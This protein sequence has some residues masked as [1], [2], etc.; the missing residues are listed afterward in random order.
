MDSCLT[1]LLWLLVGC[2]NVNAGWWLTIPSAP[3]ANGG[4]GSLTS[5]S[6]YWDTQ[7]SFQFFH[8]NNQ[9]SGTIPKGTYGE[10]IE[11]YFCTTNVDSMPLGSYCF[12]QNRQN[13]NSSK[14]T[15]QKDSIF[16]FLFAIK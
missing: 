15:T 7:D 3:T 1:L 14:L 13:C 2:V 6:Y 12:Y 4:C 11:Q 5:D 9:W 8:N 10:N 16:N